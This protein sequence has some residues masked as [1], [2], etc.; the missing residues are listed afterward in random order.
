MRGSS[1]RTNELIEYGRRLLEADNPQTLQQLHYAIFSRKEIPY[2][3][4]Q[5]DYKRLSRATS[6]ARRAYRAW[7]LERWSERGFM[8]VRAKLPQLADR[9]D[10]AL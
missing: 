5:A 4:T 6:F 7:A 1:A 9:R 3:N 2:S 8:S 10:T